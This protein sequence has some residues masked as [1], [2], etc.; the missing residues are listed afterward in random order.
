MSVARTS[1][2]EQ[3]SKQ[4]LAKHNEREH[5]I[6]LDQQFNIDLRRERKSVSD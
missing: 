3:D 4:R 2:F 5:L 6:F 1:S